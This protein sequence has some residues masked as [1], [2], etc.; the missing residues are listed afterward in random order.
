MLHRAATAYP[1]AIQTILLRQDRHTRK[2]GLPDADE[3]VHREWLSGAVLSFTGCAVACI[4]IKIVQSPAASR[5]P[6]GEMDCGGDR[7]VEM[8]MGR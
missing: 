8:E 3:I 7:Y 2:V 1:G 6:R 4:D 5:S